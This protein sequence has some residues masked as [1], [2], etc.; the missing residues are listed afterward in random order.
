MQLMLQLVAPESQ[1]SRAWVTRSPVAASRAKSTLRKYSKSF[2]PSGLVFADE[3]ARDHGAEDVVG[4][5]ADR[6]QRRV[7][8]KALDLVLGGV[9]VSAVNA[10]RLE[11]GP[12][13][14]L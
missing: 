7:T 6:H 5:F 9:A 14:D 11:R 4:A 3:L 12:D 10:H 8:V 2:P 13:A 1:S